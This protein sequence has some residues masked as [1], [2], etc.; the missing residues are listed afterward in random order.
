M[1]LQALEQE[2]V[3][4]EV[5][6]CTATMDLNLAL[7]ELG[8]QGRLVAI[9]RLVKYLFANG[10]QS[11]HTIASVFVAYGEAHRLDLALSRWEAWTR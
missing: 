4:A 9:D 3:Q 11:D 8:R 6:Q 1:L 5:L 2:P 10:R 7:P